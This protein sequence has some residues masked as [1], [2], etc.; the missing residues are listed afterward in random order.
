MFKNTCLF[1]MTNAL[2]W[3]N[4]EFRVQRVR[5]Y[6]AQVNGFI[7]FYVKYFIDFTK[8]NHQLPL[9]V[10]MCLSKT[11]QLVCLCEI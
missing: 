3:L 6:K 4:H 1:E 11:T 10:T 2:F 8:N 5:I 7:D 9:S